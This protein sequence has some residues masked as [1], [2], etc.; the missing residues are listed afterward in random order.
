MTW[1]E[2]KQKSGISSLE[3]VAFKRIK[4]NTDAMYN[5]SSEL[6]NIGRDSAHPARHHVLYLDTADADTRC[7]S[8]GCACLAP[9]CLQA[10]YF[11]LSQRILLWQYPL[12]VL[13]LRSSSCWIIILWIHTSQAATVR[14][15]RVSK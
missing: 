12:L 7:V 1:Q 10:R 15:D 4:A 13:F 9:V 11:F 6:V 2:E 14:V 8:D 5:I 3:S